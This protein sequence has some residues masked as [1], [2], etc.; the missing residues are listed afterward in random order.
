M[1][2]GDPT[3]EAILSIAKLLKCSDKIPQLKD[4]DNAPLQRV[5]NN[6]SIINDTP[7][8]R[9]PV[10]KTKTVHVIP[11]EPDESTHSNKTAPQVTAE[12]LIPTSLPKNIRHQNAPQNNY[13]LRSKHYLIQHVSSNYTEKDIADYL[14]FPS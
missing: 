8:P 3:Y 4:I 14:F 9:M 10:T 6:K 2:A 7:L 12:A 5:I 1:T 11:M 13:N